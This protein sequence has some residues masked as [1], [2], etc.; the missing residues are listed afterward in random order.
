M[1]EYLS[2]DVA[3]YLPESY[4]AETVTGY[5][6]QREAMAD[7]MSRSDNAFLEMPLSAGPSYS[8]VLIKVLSRGTV[9][10]DPEDIYGEPV[11]DYHTYG[12][13]TDKHMMRSMVR[14]IRKAHETEAMAVLGPVEV[15]PGEDVQ[16][17]EEID[18]FLVGSTSCSTAHNSGTC[19]MMPRDLGGVVGADLLVH[20]VKGL[21]VADSSIMPI[22]PVSVPPV[23][24]GLSSRMD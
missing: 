16:S 23:E 3:E 2:L 10:L 13:P 14:W 1:E 5:E 8:S 7:M 18:E 6:A 21:S 15:Q 22:I 9:L 20:G 24:I 12:I 17:D 4:T 19:P 11:V